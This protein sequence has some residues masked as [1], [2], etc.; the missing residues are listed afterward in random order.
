[1][2]DVLV[3]FSKCSLQYEFPFS[4]LTKSDEIMTVKDLDGALWVFASWRSSLG[5][6]YE[7]VVSHLFHICLEGLGRC[8]LADIGGGVS[9]VENDIQ[10]GNVVVSKPTGSSRGVV[11]FDYG[12]TV[13]NGRWSSAEEGC[14]DLDFQHSSAYR[15]P[16]MEVLFSLPVSGMVARF[17]GY[18]EL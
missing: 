15:L 9:S 18:H 16:I 2:G 11:M 5:R 1:M 12:K 7:I 4:C 8:G 6:H 17:L 14:E 13:A 10:L 3:W